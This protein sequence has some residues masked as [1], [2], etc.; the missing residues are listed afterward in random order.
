[1]KK[2]MCFWGEGY[3]DNGQVEIREEETFC[4]NWGYEEDDI[5][6]VSSLDIA[7]SVD[8]SDPSGTHIV[9]RLE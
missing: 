1:M 7:D 4:E 6:R 5:A 8:L 3:N 9:T 2:F